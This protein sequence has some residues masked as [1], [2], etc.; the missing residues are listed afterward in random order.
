MSKKRRTV[1]SSQK[2]LT[3][4]L[5][6][7][8][9]LVVA[10]AFFW[11]SLSSNAPSDTSAGNDYVAQAATLGNPDAPVVITEYADF[12]C[13][14]CRYLATTITPQLIEE[15]VNTG[16]VRLEYRHFAHYGEESF[17][18]GMAAECAN[19]QGK[20][21]E[22]HDLLFDVQRSPNSGTFTKVKLADYAARLGLETGAFTQCVNSGRYLSKIK[23]DTQQARDRGGTGTPTIF[24]N[25][26]MLGGVPPMDTLRQLIQQQLDSSGMSSVTRISI[27]VISINDN[28]DEPF[29][30]SNVKFIQ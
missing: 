8:V 14:A 30:L 27:S 17:W 1:K 24:I 29:T 21:W 19:E 13:S 9:L 6:G 16:K 20:F 26:H 22:F 15:Y 2:P 23:A 11:W 28:V 5:L 4:A 18:A 7:V 10:G 12:Q 3:I 25:D